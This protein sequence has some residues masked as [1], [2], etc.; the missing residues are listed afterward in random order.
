MLDI[1]LGIIAIAGLFTIN[2][3]FE[4]GQFFIRT[5]TIVNSALPVEDVNEMLGLNI[6]TDIGNTLGGVVSY[7]CKQQDEPPYVGKVFKVN[8]AQILIYSMDDDLINKLKVS[9]L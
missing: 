5:G 7:L 6:P 8:D 3:V 9:K 1:V 4:P 2:K